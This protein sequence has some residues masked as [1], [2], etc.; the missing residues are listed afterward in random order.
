MSYRRSF[1][2][3][4]THVL[5]EEPLGGDLEHDRRQ[6]FAAL[7]AGRCYIAVDALAPAR[8][9]GFWAENGARRVEMG[10]E[11]P[12]GDWTLRVEL[13][14]EA[15]VRYFRD[16]ERTETQEVN[17]PGVYRAEAHRGDKTWV[18]S[19]PIYLR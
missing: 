8:G 3:I 2:H 11:A 12:A 6:V 19:N 17:G 15:E 18:I 1:R 16:G 5:T 10:E 13:P 9:F 4:R 7:R 14:A